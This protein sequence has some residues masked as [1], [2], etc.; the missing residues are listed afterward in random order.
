MN[1]KV[2]VACKYA[3]WPITRLEIV[4]THPKTYVLKKS[5]VTGEVTRTNFSFSETEYQTLPY[6]ELQAAELVRLIDSFCGPEGGLF[7][8]TH[9]PITAGGRCRKF[10]RWAFVCPWSRSLDSCVEYLF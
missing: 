10:L 3:A 8:L 2:C 6:E 9:T 1:N 7:E 4:C 5:T